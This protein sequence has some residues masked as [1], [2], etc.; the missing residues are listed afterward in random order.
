MLSKE[1]ALRPQKLPKGNKMVSVDIGER[2]TSGP[3]SPVNILIKPESAPSEPSSS[4]LPINR[5][6]TI[7]EMKAGVWMEGMVCTDCT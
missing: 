5:V 3:A 1:A 2:G 4:T 7:A 6:S